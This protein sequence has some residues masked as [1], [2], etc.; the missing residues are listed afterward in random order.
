MMADQQV[1]PK[2]RMDLLEGQIAHLDAAIVAL[3][4][5][6]DGHNPL[7]AT[8]VLQL[9]VNKNRMNVQIAI[10]SRCCA[11]APDIV[12]HTPEFETVI[13]RAIDHVQLLKQILDLHVRQ[14]RPVPIGESL[15]VD[16]IPVHHV[17]KTQA[18]ILMGMGRRGAR[19]H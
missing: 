1:V 10:R 3:D 12:P 14:Q 4:E 6:F 8:C 13:P 16:H 17:C 19:T 2:D 15:A 7:H 18:L 9:L 5:R 11:P